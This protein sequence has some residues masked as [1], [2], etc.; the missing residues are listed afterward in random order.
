MHTFGLN[1]LALPA[2]MIFLVT[3]LVSLAATRA[4]VLSLI[5]A[6][7]KSLIFLIYFAYFF[8]GTYSFIDDMTYLRQGAIFANRG[9]GLTTLAHDWIFVLAVAGSHFVFQIFNTYAIYIFGN[10]YF[11]PVVLTILLTPPTAWLGAKLAAREFSFTDER[12]TLFYF[13]FLLFP[14]TLVWSSLVNGK[15]TLVLLL[16]VVLLYSVSL[17]FRERVARG[18]TIAVAA[19]LVLFSLRFYVPLMFGAALVVTL[20]LE[21]RGRR[22]GRMIVF[23]S[24]LL[25][26]LL[27]ALGSTQLVWIIGRLREDLVNPFYGFVRF[28]LTPIPLHTDYNYEFLDLPATFHWL[29][30]PMSVLG[31]VAAVKQNTRFS[32]FFLL[33][34][35][36]FVG[37]Y[38][39]YGELQEPRHRL[40]LDYAW[41]I[42]QFFGWYVLARNSWNPMRAT[43]DRD[44]EAS[45]SRAQVDL[46]QWAG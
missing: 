6:T 17:M 25:L 34:F 10:N 13:Y 41:A 4:P 45:I 29:L 42:F 40:Q 24:G 21:V 32:R 19:S 22:R 28:L 18:L 46:P 9:I 36:A 11:S 27:A 43:A 12:R 5:A 38:S 23:S 14:N 37:L 3:S 33:Y 31:L 2:A 30:L 16:H 1:L 7:I 20:L 15:D 35:F 39:I 26:V 44:S 8:D